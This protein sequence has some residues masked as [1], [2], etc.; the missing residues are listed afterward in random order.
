[1]VTVD[2]ARADFRPGWDRT[3]PADNC[4]DV[5]LIVIDF[6]A[7]S[8]FHT[9]LTKKGGRLVAL[10]P[11]A[12]TTAS[13]IIHR[14]RL[15]GHQFEGNVLSQLFGRTLT[16]IPIAATAGRLQD[17]AAVRRYQLETLALQLLP[18]RKVHS[19]VCTCTS[20]CATLRGML[21]PFEHGKERKR[22][23]MSGTDLDLHTQTT[24]IL[25]RTAG[26]RKKLLPPNDDWSPVFDDFHWHR[27]DATGKCCRGQAVESWPSS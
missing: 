26:V 10:E 19:T 21:D 15:S 27:L 16:R 14:R 22:R 25:A 13:T 4:V 7:S 23:R 3:R 8:T 9:S 1:M 12:C 17:Q 11:T 6:D 18:E 2:A 24:A 20:A 5:G